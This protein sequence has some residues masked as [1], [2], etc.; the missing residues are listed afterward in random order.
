MVRGA[1]PEEE[2]HRIFSR[3]ARLTVEVVIASPHRGVLLALRE[4][5]P[6]AGLW[7]LPGGTVR[8]GEPVVD[9]VAR[10]ARDELG[11]TVTAGDLLGVIEYPSHYESG[12]DSPVGM[13]F[14]AEPVGAVPP[15]DALRSRCRWFSRLPAEIHDE[16]RDFLTAHVLGP[17]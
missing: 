15:L 17:T 8:F 5:G 7:H 1:L 13:A 9:A 2:F 11:I 14:R 10:V 16:Q 4:A 3:V 12:L 6:C